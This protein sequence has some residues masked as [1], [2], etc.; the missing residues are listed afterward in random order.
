[1]RKIEI[2]RPGKVD[3]NLMNVQGPEVLQLL[4]AEDV[5]RVPGDE[6]VEDLEV[7][8]LEEDEGHEAVRL[9]VVGGLGVLRLNEGNALQLL[10]QPR[11]TLIC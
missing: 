4:V 5:V 11:S 10:N 9:E 2:C 6:E 3:Q 8:H 7:L 1:M